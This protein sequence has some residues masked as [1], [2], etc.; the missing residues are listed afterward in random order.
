MAIRAAQKAR[1]SGDGDG[2]GV[3]HAEYTLRRAEDAFNW[4]QTDRPGASPSWAREFPKADRSA[5]FRDIASGFPKSG[6]VKIIRRRGGWSDSGVGRA[7]RRAGARSG[8]PRLLVAVMGRSRST[9]CARARD[10]IALLAR[11]SDASRPAD[12]ES[13]WSTPVRPG[14]LK[15]HAAGLSADI[16][17]AKPRIAAVSGNEASR[18]TAQQA[19]RKALCCRGSLIFVAKGWK[20]PGA[21]RYC[22]SGWMVPLHRGR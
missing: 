2:T 17:G 21:V 10:G 19:P 11:K 15:N 22:A 4:V 8:A 3:R 6:G 12:S 14:F 9:A 18:Q 16:D 5:D 1:R 7:S 20:Y 13:C